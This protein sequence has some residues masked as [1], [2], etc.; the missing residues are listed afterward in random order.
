MG[1]SEYIPFYKMHLLAGRNVLPGDSLRELVINETLARQMGCPSPNQ[2]VGRM[3]YGINADGSIGKPYPIV[4]VVADFHVSSFHDPIPPVVIENV[5]ERKNSIAIK[6]SAA[7][8]DT[9]AILGQ[10]EM[11]WKAQFPADRSFQS[12]FLDESISSLFGQEKKT[13]WLINRAMGVTIFL[14]CM[15]LFG[16]G[17]FTIRRRTKEISIRKVLGAS[18]TAI[19]TLIGKDFALLVG[20]AFCI[21]TPLAWWATHRW[22]QDFVYRTTLDWWIFALAGLGALLIA[23][24]TVSFQSIR[25]AMVNPVT[26]LRNE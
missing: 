7:Q 14:S 16:L 19:T 10:L 15:G 13:A 21:A 3:L 6:L 20:L 4:G 2:A 25:A 18:I 9:K 12:A 23:M 22:L 5:M 8:K 24:L 1:N 11:Q 17:L 26:H